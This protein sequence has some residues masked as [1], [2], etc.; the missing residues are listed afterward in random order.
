MG[1]Q[2]IIKHCNT[3]N[4]LTLANNN[5]LRLTFNTPERSEDLK[6]TEAEVQMAVLTSSS[7]VPLAFH[8]SLSPTIRRIFPNSKIASKYYS[9]STKATCMLNEAVAP[10]LIEDLLET[11]KLHPFSLAVD[12]SNYEGLAKIN[13]LTVRIFDVNANRIVTRFLDMCVHQVLLLLKNWQSFLA[14]HTHGT[15]ALHLVLKTHLS[16]LGFGNH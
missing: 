13:P 10:M 9:A 8:D 3:K 16:I 12:G 4:H 14:V 11:M 7:N 6:R 1:K 15:C 5:Q 2:D